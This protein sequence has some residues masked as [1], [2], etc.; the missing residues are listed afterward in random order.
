MSHVVV[1][2]AGLGGLRTVESLR[3]SGFSG[4]ISL[5]GDE[6]HE[7]YDR[8]PLSKQILAG[9]W[10]EER[11]TLHRGEL[12][13]LGASLYLGR[14]AIGLDDE[15]VELD[16]GARLRYDTLVVATGVRARRLPG[17]PDHPELH[18]LRTLEDCR[19]LR[20]SISRARSLLVVGAGFIGAEVAATARM[21][22]LEVTML[23]AL[24]VPFARV[25]GD[26]M[27]QLCARLQGDNGVTVR[28]GVRLDGFLLNGD[29]GIAAQLADGNVVRADCGV[30]G[31]GTVID[32]GWLT[33]LGLPTEGG[34]LCDATGLVEGTG[35]VYGVGDIAAWRHPTFGDRPRIE[36][37]TSATEQAAVVAQ[38]IAGAEVTRAADAVPYF[39][40]D[41]YGLTLQL[42]GRCDLATSVEV[43]HDPGVIKGTVAGYFADGALVAVLA[44]HAPRLLNRYRRLVANGASEHEVHSAAAELAFR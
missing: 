38:H 28:C 16:D 20:G 33:G 3:A 39:W 9:T 21:A 15:S 10:P 43:L 29:G 5:V 40:S 37:W 23:E 18:V 1:V 34:L 4:R 24:P 32:A 25:L 12:A 8:P 41:Q 6:V 35:N 19:A 14:S 36:H 2:G 26:Q 44:F 30:V 42:I 7:P 22:G 27:G 11:A 13:D 31:V 17:Q